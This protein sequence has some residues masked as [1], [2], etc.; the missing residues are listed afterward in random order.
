MEPVHLFWGVCSSMRH[1]NVPKWRQKS[2]WPIW[3][4]LIFCA[5]GHDTWILN[6]VNSYACRGCSRAPWPHP[7]PIK[8]NHHIFHQM[9][10]V[11]KFGEFWAIFRARAPI[12]QTDSVGIHT[13]QCS[14]PNKNPSDS[15]SSWG[16]FRPPKLQLNAEYKNNNKNPG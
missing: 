12:I 6:L 2:K 14:G 7:H 11:V 9:W 15:N 4:V 3:C 10:C 8:L 16:M 5:S 1:R 13:G